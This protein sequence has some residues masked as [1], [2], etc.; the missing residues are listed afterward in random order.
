MAAGKYNDG[1]PER[2]AE[3]A[4]RVYAAIAS[5][6]E[7]AQ[8]S[9]NQRDICG[10]HVDASTGAKMIVLFAMVLLTCVCLY[11]APLETI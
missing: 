3:L 9:A 4:A 8:N 2:R 5:A 7:Q 11:G 1:K 10:E 6:W